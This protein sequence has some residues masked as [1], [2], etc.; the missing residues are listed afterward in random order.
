MSRSFWS[1]ER[2]AGLLESRGPKMS[3]LLFGFGAGH[4]NWTIANNHSKRA[5]VTSVFGE[6]SSKRVQLPTG[7]TLP[8]E[9]WLPN[10]HWQNSVERRR[11]AGSVFLST[12]PKPGLD[13]AGCRLG[14]RTS[15]GQLGIRQLAVSA[16]RL[17][18]MKTPTGR[19]G[20]RSNDFCLCREASKHRDQFVEPVFTAKRLVSR[21]IELVGGFRNSLAA[22][23]AVAVL[24]A[25]IVPVSAGAGEYYLR[26]G[27]GFD[28]PNDAEFRDVDHL[29]AGGLY[30]CCA[31]PGSGIGRRSLG[32]YGS[33]AALELGVGYDSGSLAR[34]E[35]LVDYRPNLTFSGVPNY[36][37]PPGAV[38]FTDVTLSSV[39]AMVAAFIDLDRIRFSNAGPYRPFIG[40]GIGAVR[41][42]VRSKIITWP[43]L[44][45]IVPGGSHVDKAWMVTTGLSV[46]LDDRATFEFAWRYTDLGEVRTG[47]GE[48]RVVRL[49]GTGD[50]S[51]LNLLPTWA[52]LRGHGI[53]LSMR[54]SF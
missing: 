52:R 50:P 17:A 48:G 24:A 13:S 4:V 51:P 41:N 14:Q 5:V 19:A 53:R 18:R 43:P 2:R 35:F 3:G 10:I 44:M 37:R 33:L 38:Q 31:P 40:A 27:L 54:H 20:N 8:A 28:K 47:T 36:S 32:G 26:T 12:N 30:G 34:Y 39:S 6:R 11:W 15:G 7:L 16:L 23:L 46:A 21:V 29:S 1:F 9:T 22:G 45:T 42:T 49:N 25:A